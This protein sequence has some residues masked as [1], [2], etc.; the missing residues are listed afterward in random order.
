M[1]ENE[2]CSLPSWDR[3][4]LMSIEIYPRP[5]VRHTY[6]PFQPKK[7]RS[8]HPNPFHYL[9]PMN[10]TH[11]QQARRFNLPVQGETAFVEY[12][13]EDNTLHLVYSEVP[14]HLRGQG[15]GK[16]LVE[17]TFEALTREGYKAEAVCG[18]IRLIAARSEKWRE[19]IKH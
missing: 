15:I 13:Q 1:T 11:D 12:R 10:L 2:H 5:H 7:S 4:A 14:G 6:L 16:V 8:S 18:Y 17:Q 3:S 19:V 9:P